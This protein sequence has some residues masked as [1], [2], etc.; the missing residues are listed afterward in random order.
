MGSS[1]HT[2]FRALFVGSTTI[3][4]LRVC[5]VPILLVT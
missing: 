3:E 2:R 5:R 1:G 4:M